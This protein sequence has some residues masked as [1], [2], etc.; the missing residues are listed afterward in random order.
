MTGWPL[1]AR[2]QPAPPA[3]SSTQGPCPLQLPTLGR[4]PRQSKAPVSASGRLG[5][6][7]SSPHSP[8][9]RT[10][11]LGGAA[12]AGCG[13][14]WR[15]LVA[16][17]SLCLLCWRAPEL[18]VRQ[19]LGEGCASH[20]PPPTPRGGARGRGPASDA[21]AP[22]LRA[23]RLCSP[24]GRSPRKGLLTLSPPAYSWTPSP[25]GSSLTLSS[26]SSSLTLSP[27]S[28]SPTPS[29]HLRSDSGVP[30][31]WLTPHLSLDG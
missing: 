11:G 16:A 14:P 22:Q 8:H 20:P 3:V 17:L 15:P 24:P 25:A 18:R 19:G 26:L 12:L 13:G 23:G 9:P 1:G 27:P 10:G 21:D 4:G 7:S 28:N 31:Q 6:G 29:S 5:K 30:A 2:P